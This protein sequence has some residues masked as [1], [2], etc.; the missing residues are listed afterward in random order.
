M[1]YPNLVSKK[2]EELSEIEFLSEKNESLKNVIITSLTEGNDIE[3]LNSKINDDY[4]KLIK[5]I[6]E[7]SNIQIIV[8]NKTDKDILELTL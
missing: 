8:K 5:E 3:I 7:N 6:K 1:N 4:D 2:I